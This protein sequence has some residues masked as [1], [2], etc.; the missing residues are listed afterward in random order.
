M[1]V[2]PLLLAVLSVAF[3]R[4][5][6]KLPAVTRSYLIGATDSAATSVTVNAKEV[7][8]YRT[9]AFCTMVD[10][11]PGSNTVTVC[12]GRGETLSVDFTV[13][14]PPKPSAGEAKPAKAKPYEKLPYTAD[15]AKEPPKGRPPSEIT[16]VLDAGHGGS[17]SGAL[18]PHGLG[19]KDANLRMAKAVAK[20]LRGLGYRVVMTREDDATV[21]LYDRPKVAHRENADAFV[22][23]HHNAPGC[24]KDPRSV[25]YHAV[26]AW[27]E[28]GTRLATAVNRRMAAAFGPSLRSNGVIRANF[29]V[30]RNP[31]IP[32]CLIEVDFLTTPE[33]EADVWNR[34]RRARIA[35]AIALGI[36]DSF[37]S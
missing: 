28:I 21:G 31:E 27:N 25:R 18:S 14:K 33:G 30:T 7:P 22:S 10:V 8:V 2:L 1:T 20:E 13:E 26:Y 19:E 29:A 35:E 4:G 12:D 9:G 6:A 17:D 37:G 16:V 34:E 3:P 23:I 36:A 15:R 5:G 11:V 32:S 24:D